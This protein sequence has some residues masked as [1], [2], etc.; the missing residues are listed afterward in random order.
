MEIEKQLTTHKSYV[1]DFQLKLLI[2]QFKLACEEIWKDFIRQ[3]CGFWTSICQMR[4]HWI[5]DSCVV[6]LEQTYRIWILFLIDFVGS[7]IAFLLD[8]WITKEKSEIFFKELKV[9]KSYNHAPV[10]FAI[11]GYE[12]YFEQFDRL[13]HLV[14]GFAGY[15][16]NFN[17][18]FFICVS[19]SLS[20]VQISNIRWH[21]DNTVH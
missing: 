1:I 21:S 5:F 11:A 6:F 12:N 19:F 2:S 3:I 9:R 17:Y 15:L 7:I 10:T 13:R 8:I 4:W 16:I 20:S 14:W 18:M